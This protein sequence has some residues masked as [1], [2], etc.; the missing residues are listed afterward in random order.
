M[1]YQSRIDNLL[2]DFDIS[3]EKKYGIML[4]G[5]LDSAVLL[6]LVVREFPSIKIQP[7]TINKADGAML[8]VNPIIDHFNKKFNLNI[9][10]TIPVGD[11]LA[12]HRE[13]SKTAVRDILQ[14]H[15]VDIIF[16]ALNKN[17]EELN[18][19]PGA[20]QRSASSDHPKLI[21]PFVNLLKHH[22]LDFVYEYNQEDLID[23][24]HSCTEQPVERCNKCWQCTERA[25]A[26][27]KLGK[28]DTGIG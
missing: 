17:P 6:Y 4:S 23:I 7:F 28:T 1:L 14:N 13:Q 11:P 21:L 20:P 5:G 26:F 25:W 18:L 3:L 8:Y 19:L 10:Y 12:Y 15:S 16:N 9:P 22:I 2:I 24:T 27:S